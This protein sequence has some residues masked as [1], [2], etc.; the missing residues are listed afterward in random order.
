MR[1]DVLARGTLRYVLPA[2]GVAWVLTYGLG[3]IL[4]LLLF[5][6]GVMG[7]ALSLMGTSG[8]GTAAMATEPASGVEID[9]REYATE[10]IGSKSV[11]AFFLAVGLV[12][13]AVAGMMLP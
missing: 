6:V 3:D 7:V 4:G 13:G 11:R 1:W 10:P 9:P 5:F 12:L 2:G 8:T